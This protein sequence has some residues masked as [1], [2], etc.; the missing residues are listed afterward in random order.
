MPHVCSSRPQ[1]QHGWD[2]SA[3]FEKCVTNRPTASNSHILLPQSLG[4]GEDGPPECFSVIVEID[5]LLHSPLHLSPPIKKHKTSK[6]NLLDLV[7]FWVTWPPSQDPGFSVLSLRKTDAK[8]QLTVKCWPRREAFYQR[9][10]PEW[11]DWMHQSVSISP[12][13][14]L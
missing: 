1:R 7:H 11:K 5:K 13:P 3:I 12:I 2:Q 4:R 10:K 9:T 14:H 6:W 8:C